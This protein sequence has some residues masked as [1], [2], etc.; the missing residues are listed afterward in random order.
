M[1]EITYL[2]DILL[3]SASVRPAATAIC[4]GEM[5]NGD[6]PHSFADVFSACEQWYRRLLERD[7]RKIA[8]LLPNCPAFSVGYFAALWSR[9][10][11]VPLNPRLTQTELLAQLNDCGAELIL[12]SDLLLAVANRLKDSSSADVLTMELDPVGNRSVN[13]AR[14]GLLPDRI[15]Q[16]ADESAREMHPD[17]TAVIL[18]T[19]GT[20]GQP[21]GAELSHDNLVHNA[22]LVCQ[23]KFSTSA[24]PTE[25]GEGDV[26]LAA[27]PLSHVFGQTNVQNGIWFGGGAISYAAKFEPEAILRQIQRDRVTFFPGVPTMFY[28]L[29]QELNGQKLESHLRFAVCGGAALST[30]CKVEF[31]KLTGV[32]IQESYG[33]TETSPMISCQKRDQADTAG[34]VGCPV[35]DTFVRIVDPETG[36]DCSTG[37]TGELWVRG[38][39]VFKGYYQRPAE[40][41]AAFHDDWF[42]TGD[43]ALQNDREE[44]QI[45]DR[46]SEM[47][48]RG[49]YMISPKEIEQVLCGVTE[50]QEA[51]VVAIPDQRM[52][53]EIKAFVVMKPSGNGNSGEESVRNKMKIACETKLASFK[54]PRFIEIIDSLPRGSTG[55]VSKLALRVQRHR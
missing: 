38:R 54:Q 9:R 37:E 31:R 34:W 20:T 19:S 18:Y 33:L 23:E 47:I 1:R 27:L 7:D 40:T 8:L 12:T 13:E 35:S 55:K 41:A 43:I 16:I 28:D 15:A 29:L 30:R 46:L 32:S 52:G 44:I 6:R 10:V 49:G 53:E 25:L 14:S 24:N 11:V 4:N 39:N 2:G 42:R 17:D 48:N 26:A 21:K 36:I 50:I 5:V 45:V 3:S 51:A 22:R